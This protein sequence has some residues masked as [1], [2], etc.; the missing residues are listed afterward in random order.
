MKK[1]FLIY[2][3]ASGRKR[4]RRAEQITRAAEVFRSAGIHAE[5]HATTHAGSAAQQTQQ[6][7]AA[8]FDTIIACGGEGPANKVFKGPR[9]FPP[10]FRVI[11]LCRGNLLTTVFFLAK[12]PATAAPPSVTD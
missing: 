1:A 10:T 9:G 7:V 6:A 12:K 11:S 4:T 2:N 5:A 8:G 3:P